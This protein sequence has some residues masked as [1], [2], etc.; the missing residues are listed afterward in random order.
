MR[1]SM[2]VLAASALIAPAASAAVVSVFGAATQI[3][4]PPI[5]NFPPLS[6]P[7]AFVWDEQ[8]GVSVSGLPCDMTVNPSNS[9]SPTPGPVFGVLDSHFIHIA[10]FT[11][12]PTIGGVIFN[13]PIVGVAYDDLFLDVSDPVVGAFGTVYPTG[14]SGRGMQFGIVQI[15][16]NVLRFDI[17]AVPGAMDI[18]QIRVYTQVPAPGAAA[19]AGLGGLMAF[20]RRRSS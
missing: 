10:N 1:P 15:N 6:G 9:T 2:L 3:G 5:A 4:N 16:A 17:P 14:Q 20:R 12:T 11:G 13:N 8:Q 19:L 7:V 18:T